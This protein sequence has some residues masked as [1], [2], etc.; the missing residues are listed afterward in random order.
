MPTTRREFIKRSAGAVAVGVVMPQ[1]WLSGARAQSANP[2]RRIFV[3]IQ[4]GG[5]N[6]GLNTVIP[7]TDSRYASLRPNLAFKDSELKDEQGQSTI[8][9]G[10]FG[11]HPALTEIKKMYDDGNVAIVLGVGYPEANLSHFLSTDIWHTANPNGGQGDGWLGKY[12]DQKL[13]G[14]SGLSAVSIGG[15]LPKALFGDMVVVPSI[16]SFAAYNYLTDPRYPGD[17]PN[18]LSTFNAGYARV[19]TPGTFLAALDNTGLDAVSGAAQV[20]AAVAGY[21][22]SVV[23]PANNPLAAGMKMLAQLVTTIPEAELL[24]VQ[25]GGFDNHS[26]QIASPNG[27]P[28]KL[29][30]DHSQ[31]LRNFSE[32]VRAFYD[33]MSEHGLADNVVMMSWSEF[34]RRPNENASFGTD[35]GTAA[36]MFVI[37]NPV[38]GGFYGVQPSLAPTALDQAGN[39]Q[40]TVDFRAVYATILERWLGADS[41]GILGTE[42]E[43]IG[44]MG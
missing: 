24:Y 2:N 30:G 32:A 35:H 6:D 20:Q 44:F 12:A 8:L 37:G 3:V 25:M 5:G 10:A 13:A 39:L 29:A 27:Q 11:L 26:S 23:Y 16:G 43:D 21:S 7:Y 1:I 42:Y 4:L 40:F 15:T 41:G 38:A 33:D 28:D 9:D 18:Q 22:S 17:R 34:G 36:P 19:F 14:E 31:L